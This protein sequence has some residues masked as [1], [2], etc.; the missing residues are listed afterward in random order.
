[1]PIGHANGKRQLI[2]FGFE[3][4]VALQQGVTQTVDYYRAEA[5]RKEQKK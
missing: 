1:M 2:G 3:P 5:A 4:K